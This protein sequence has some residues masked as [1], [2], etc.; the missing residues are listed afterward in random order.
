[1][2]ERNPRE[3]KQRKSE[4]PVAVCLE[5]SMEIY[6]KLRLVVSVCLSLENFVS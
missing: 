6:E 2:D 1:M 3:I 4:Y 5:L